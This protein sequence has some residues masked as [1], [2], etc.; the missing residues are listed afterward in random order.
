MVV[1]CASAQ[2]WWLRT[3]NSNANN[4]RNVNTS[5]AVNNN[6]AN[7][8]YAVVPDCGVCEIRV[9]FC[10]KQGTRAGRT[11]PASPE[12]KWLATLASRMD[13]PRYEGRPGQQRPTNVNGTPVRP[14]GR[15]TFARSLRCDKDTTKTQL[16]L[17]AY[18]TA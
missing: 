4:V 7:N 17:I 1:S 10:R 3:P 14:M 12:E 8:A 6:N 9:G 2:N 13:G 11:R 16:V 5:G 15:A 18:I